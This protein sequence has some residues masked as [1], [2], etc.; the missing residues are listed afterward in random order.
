[1]VTNVDG[2]QLTAVV[3]REGNRGAPLVAGAI[4]SRLRNDRRWRDTVI[5]SG[6]QERAVDPS[7]PHRLPLFPLGTVLFPGMLLPLHLF[8]ERYRR[9][10]E[11]R[12][13][14]NPIFGVVLT[15]QGHEVGDRPEVHEV[16]TAA[17]LVGA[18]RYPDGRFDI[19]VRGARRFRLLSGNWDHDYLTGDVAWLDGADGPAAESGTGLL[20]GQVARAYE[21]FLTAL[22]GAMG[23]AVPREELGGDPEGLAYAICARLPVNTWERQR[24][25]EASSSSDRLRDLLS[26]LRRERALLTET[27]AGGPALERSGLGFSSN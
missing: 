11:E 16:G 10:M 9:L 25:L 1:M 2:L 5:D 21:R 17:T 18:G 8:E 27:N 23:A 6:D 4:D 7:S 24:L 14:T 20:A 3:G 22:A 26:I 13:G 12:Q 19:V 15:R